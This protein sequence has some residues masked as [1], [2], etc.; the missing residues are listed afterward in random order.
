[1]RAGV[2][3][4]VGVGARGGASAGTH[5]RIGVGSRLGATLGAR[6]STGV[7]AKVGVKA[8]AK[9]VKIGAKAPI[10]AIA[11]IRSLHTGVSNVIGRWSE[12]VGAG[13][14]AGVLSQ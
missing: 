9:G 11:E 13:T 1:M 8:G 7:G 6:V 4:S 5:G 3:A 10:P 14:M 2:G 12:G